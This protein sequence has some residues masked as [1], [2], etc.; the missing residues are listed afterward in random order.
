[1]DERSVRRHRKQGI[2]AESPVIRG[3]GYS[4]YGPV[5]ILKKGGFTENQRNTTEKGRR[6]RVRILKSFS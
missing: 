5:Q 3:N 2:C 1:M 4:V 6:L